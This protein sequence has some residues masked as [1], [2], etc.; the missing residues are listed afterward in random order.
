[1]T[2]GWI[3][4]HRERCG[5][6]Q[7]SRDYITEIRRFVQ[8]TEMNPESFISTRNDFIRGIN[9][10]E[11]V[12]VQYDPSAF[13]FRGRDFF[14]C[15]M[16]SIT[17]PTIVTLHDI[18]REQPGIFPRNALTGIPPVKRIREWLYDFRH[19]VQTAFNRNRKRHFYTSNIMLHHLFHKT[20]LGFD[21]FSDTRTI[22]I[23]PLPVK[24]SALHRRSIV[25]QL[26]EPSFG[27]LGFINPLFNYDLL[28][29]TL[30]LIDKPWTFTWIGGL[31]SDDQRHLFDTIS[32]SIRNRNW[33][34]RFTIT[35]WVP[36]TVLDSRLASID[37]TF[38]LFTQ[39][40][41]SA[42]IARALGADSPV[43]A[44][45]LALTEEIAAFN[46]DR[47]LPSPLLISE[48]DPGLAADQINTFL[49]DSSLRKNIRKG[50]E[51]YVT[52]CS[53]PQM[54][55]ELVTLYRELAEA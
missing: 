26:H 8:V 37:L 42:S 52:S 17:V 35:G 51:A 3:Y 12:H 32:T 30:D 2:I 41:S 1:M 31:R 39:R 36:E 11:V 29:K 38:A 24:Q 49:R 50:I 13:F 5:I 18:Y 16:K 22:H 44:T 14:P 9:R 45:R 10:C 40:S 20:L 28:F 21:T 48:A 4:P 23:Q 19:P 53:Y 46:T 27:A 25:K 34:T 55:R 47:N 43:I 7:Y 33:E 6:A 15:L 54:A